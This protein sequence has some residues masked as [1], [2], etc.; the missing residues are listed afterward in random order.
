[1]T[2]SEDLKSFAVTLHFYSSQAFNF[3]RRTLHLPHPDTIR[4]WASSCGVEPGFL[5]D[6]VHS[7]QLQLANEPAMQDVCI[8]FDSNEHKETS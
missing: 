5:K 2:Y 1:M 4:R 3:L 6:V 7:L 8:I